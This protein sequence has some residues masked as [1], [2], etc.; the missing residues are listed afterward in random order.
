MAKAPTMIH[1]INL[2]RTPDRCREF[3]A[4]NKHLAHV[5]RFAAID[6]NDLDPDALLRDGTI[7]RNSTNL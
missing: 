7:E 4:T 6:G 5:S 1:F 3:L 2:D